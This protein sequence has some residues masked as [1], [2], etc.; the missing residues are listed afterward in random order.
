M[1]FSG[2]IPNGASLKATVSKSSLP[3]PIPVI[4]DR[5]KLIFDLKV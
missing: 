2:C 3:S 4:Y 1:S 5:Q